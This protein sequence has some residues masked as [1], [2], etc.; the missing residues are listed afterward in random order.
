VFDL[1]TNI[2]KWLYNLKD[3]ANMGND[4]GAIDSEKANKDLPDF[5]FSK[6]GKGFLES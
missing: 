5:E 2:N 1:D 6:T 3:T 4:P